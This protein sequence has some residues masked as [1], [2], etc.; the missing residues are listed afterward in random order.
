MS[1]FNAFDVKPKLYLDSVALMRS[2]KALSDLDGVVEAAMMMGTPSN[3][4]IMHNAGL[5]DSSTLTA[6][7][8]DLV[9]AVIATS[10][11]AAT[12]AMQQAEQM[13]SSPRSAQEGATWKPKSI[14]SAIASRPTLNLAL[15]SVPGAFAISEARKALRRGLHV[16]IF[17]DNVAIEQEAQL[18][19]EA[20]ELGKLVMGPDCGTAII[21][22]VP[23]A[24][25]N[26][27]PQGDTAIIGASGTGIQE[28]S[29]LLARQGHGISQAIGVGGRDLH[30]Q[31]GGISTEMAMAAIERDAQTRRVVLV[32]KP[33]APAI[34]DRLIKIIAQS[35]KAYTLC[36]LG[37][38]EP[39]LPANCRWAK[40]LSEAAS[41]AADTS[42][43]S[44]SAIPTSAKLQ[45][46][47]LIRGLFCGGT[48]CTESLLV[49]KQA[50]LAVS[51]NVSLPGLENHA[52]AHQL[53]DLGADEFTQGKPHPMIEPSIR[54][55][56]VRQALE[57]K[58]TGV[59][60]VDVVLGFGAHTDP[61]GQL[62]SAIN[63][64]K[65]AN[66]S[67]QIVASVTGTE[68]DPQVF[69]RQVK[70]LESAGIIVANSNEAATRL[71]LAL[72]EPDQAK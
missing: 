39:E 58:Q 49:F 62:V 40:T 43:S 51:S 23:L 57:D 72:V 47:K 13:L 28:I 38:T 42:L 1:T 17:S 54:D 16:M 53:L 11:S 6:T 31:V 7:P 21:N 36:F 55:M 59:L 20:K 34:V 5:I 68:D 66:N 32:S 25:A 8:S 12:A 41:I 18:K 35:S 14:R 4:E 44:S 27:V 67:V 15:I 50:G 2:S 48:L 56:P 65:L 30:E 71:A 64:C 10:D 24:F 3:L 46:G 29:C 52:D 70:T 33:P 37:G 63:E 61:A 26:K 60:L 9:I 19:R 22:G 45:A 69:S